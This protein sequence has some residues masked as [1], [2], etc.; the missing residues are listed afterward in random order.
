MWN[1]CTT[2]SVGLSTVCRFLR[3]NYDV[4]SQYIFV[5]PKI[6]N[7]I[8]DTIL[9]VNVLQILTITSVGFVLFAVMWVT[10]IEEYLE[11]RERQ[12]HESETRT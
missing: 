1:G 10:K 6:I 4:F 12:Q 8:P 2:A 3:I 9:N 5:G 11:E 7:K